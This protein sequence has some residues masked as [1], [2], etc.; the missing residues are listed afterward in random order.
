MG[1]FAAARYIARMRFWTLLGRSL[2]LRCPLCG[3]GR[4]FRGLWAMN[5]RCEV[6]DADF[7]REA[8]FYLG[9]IYVNYGL[10]TL[11]VSIAYPALLFTGTLSNDTLLWTSIAFILLFPLLIFRH[12]RS[13]WLGFDQLCDPR[14]GEIGTGRTGEKSDEA[15][16]HSR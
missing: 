16:R 1:Q 13:I 7:H 9:S 14:P 10:T 2:R 3:Q 12:S 5:D 6:C 15:K 11:I 8:G 4:L